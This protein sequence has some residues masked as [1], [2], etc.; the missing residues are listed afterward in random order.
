VVQLSDTLKPPEI[1]GTPLKS[2]LHPIVKDFDCI[3][4]TEHDSAVP[5]LMVS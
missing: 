3:L 1:H 2:E 5:Q 4:P